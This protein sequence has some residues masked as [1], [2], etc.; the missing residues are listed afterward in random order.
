MNLQIERIQSLCDSLSLPGLNTEY[1]ALAQSGDT[2]GKQLYRLPGA[3]P[4]G[5]TAIPATAHPQCIAQNGRLPGD[6]A[7]Q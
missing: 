7:A 2:T 3:M 5:R 6:P 1:E 4:A